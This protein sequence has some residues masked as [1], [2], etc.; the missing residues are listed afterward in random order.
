[1]TYMIFFALFTL[2]Q[3]WFGIKNKTWGFMVGMVIGVILEAVGYY[4]RLGLHDDPFS[5]AAFLVYVSLGVTEVQ[6]NLLTPT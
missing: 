2:P 5:D 1:M 3:L 4:A 6:D